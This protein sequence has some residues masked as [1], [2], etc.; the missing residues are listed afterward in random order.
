MTNKIRA[1]LAALYR[2]KPGRTFAQ[3]LVGLL[4]G[5]TVFD[6]DWTT[7]LGGAALAGLV[8]LLQ[9]WA[10]GGELLAA[11]AR[12]TGTKATAGP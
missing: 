5:S 10:E 11:D 8:S 3:A 12:V 7:A 1:A 2:F 4:V 9:I 6:I